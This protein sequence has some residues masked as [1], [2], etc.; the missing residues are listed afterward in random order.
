MLEDLTIDAQNL[1]Y[2]ELN[3]RIREKIKENNKNIKLIN[4]NGQRY[5]CAGIT[6]SEIN[7]KVIGIPGNDLG[8][9]MNGP[10]IEVL[11]N[12][13]DGVGNTMNDGKIII[14]GIAG[15]IIG[16]GMRG[17]SIYVKGNV[18]YRVGI[19]MKEYQEKI[20]VIV[21]GGYAG[22]FLGEYMAG[23]R[24]IVLGLDLQNKEDIVGYY[25]STGIHGGVIYLRG[26]VPE[27][28]LGKEGKVLET[29]EKD[30]DFISFHVK[31]F[32]EYFHIDY[33]YIISEKFY[34]IVPY[35]KRPYGNLYAY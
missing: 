17:G 18:G 34:K 15:D 8:A 33:E 21:I 4:V 27:Y 14:H 6:G 11:G 1:H 9:F 24:I 30:M 32:S 19:H 29:D 26:F 7:V 23:G 20:P 3:L 31:K 35:N 28:K 10:K 2:K 5:I 13:Q 12:A 25:C 16:Y 22:D